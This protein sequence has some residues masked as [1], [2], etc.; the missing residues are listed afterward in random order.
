L[1]P[2]T[3]PHRPDQPGSAIVDTHLQVPTRFHVPV[4]GRL[5]WQDA[6]RWRFRQKEVPFSLRPGQPLDIPIQAEVQAGDY[7]RTPGV[8]IAFEPN[9]FHNRFIDLYPIKLAGPSAVAV[10]SATVP[11]HIDGQLDDE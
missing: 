11:P 5:I 2:A 10:D 7:P 8:T 6:P 1:Q 4:K 3:G 9:R